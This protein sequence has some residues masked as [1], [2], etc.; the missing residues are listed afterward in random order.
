MH[1]YIQSHP[2]L[3]IRRICRTRCEGCYVFVQD[4]AA[5]GDGKRLGVNMLALIKQTK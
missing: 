3:C 2:Q 1:T 5:T 4:Q